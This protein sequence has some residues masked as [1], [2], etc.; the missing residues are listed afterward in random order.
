MKLKEFKKGD[1]I[2]R[3]KHFENVVTIDSFNEN[4]GTT[5][6]RKFRDGRID[7]SFIGKALEFIC[8]T[9]GLVLLQGAFFRPKLGQ[10][11]KRYCQNSCHQ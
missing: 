10:L 1:I 8:I 5:T 2:T 4:L 11:H 3:T 9:N 7:N 6:V